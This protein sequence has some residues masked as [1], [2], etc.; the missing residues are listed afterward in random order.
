MTY[1]VLGYQTYV[2]WDKVYFSV[3]ADSPEEALEIVKLNPEEYY[4]DAKGINCEDFEFVN[5]E[6]W[7]VWEC[8]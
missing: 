2:S 3:E 6:D 1:E 7:E 8:E 4:V 5:E